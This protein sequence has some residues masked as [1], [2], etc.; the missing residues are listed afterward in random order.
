MSSDTSTDNTDRTLAEEI[1][2]T[3]VVDEPDEDELVY[4]L[5]GVIEIVDRSWR[6][7]VHDEIE[8]REPKD[9][10]FTYLL[11]KYA[12]ARVSD[13]DSPVVAT[14]EELNQ[15]FDRGLV[16]DVCEH[17]WV[18]HWDGNV[19]IRPPFFVHTAAELNARY[20]DTGNKWSEKGDSN[21]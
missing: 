2:D 15:H 8:D 4:A 12:A 17:G 18:R 1:R 6:I 7:V 10:V 16:K 9:R 20:V 13:S 21:V 3:F 14:R 19:Q 5:E 11:A